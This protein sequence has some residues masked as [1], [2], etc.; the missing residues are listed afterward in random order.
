MCN[1]GKWGN[2]FQMWMGA[3]F[4]QPGSAG[5]PVNLVWT[6]RGRDESS[7]HTCGALSRAFLCF[8]CKNKSAEMKLWS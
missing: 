5:D 3:H 1:L 2:A 6:N 4:A 7:A 8:F